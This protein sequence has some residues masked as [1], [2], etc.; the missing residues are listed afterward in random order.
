MKK[1]RY[2]IGDIIYHYRT[3]ILAVIVVEPESPYTVVGAQSMGK[4]A[5]IFGDWFATNRIRKMELEDLTD[6]EVAEIVA[7]K[8]KDYD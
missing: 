6:E 3:K 5:S 7:F 4:D 1:N 8:L 2:K